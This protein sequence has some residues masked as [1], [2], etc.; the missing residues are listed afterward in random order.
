[1]F[2][3]IHPLTSPPLPPPLFQKHTHNNTNKQLLRVDTRV[4]GGWCQAEMGPGSSTWA[5]F[6][7]QVQ[8]QKYENPLSYSGYR[9]GGV[10]VPAAHELITGSYFFI[11]G[12]F[13]E[14][15]TPRG[16]TGPKSRIFGNPDSVFFSLDLF[17]KKYVGEI[18]KNK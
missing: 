9:D 16:V 13:L 4:A 5:G 18:S 2:A 12:R 17:L 10:G 14:I 8:Q 6:G 7:D 15:R 11:G 3:D 1:M